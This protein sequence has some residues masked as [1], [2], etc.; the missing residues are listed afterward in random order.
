MKEFEFRSAL[1]REVK[2]Y[3]N[4]MPEL[5][6]DILDCS[7]GVNPYGYAENVV[8][9]I[10]NFDFDIFTDYPHSGVLR[11]QLVDYWRGFS[12]V[13][14]DE[15]TLCNGSVCGLYYICELFARGSRDRVIGYIPSFTDMI[16][17]VRNFGMGYD[18]V[19]IRLDEGG[20]QNPG[21]II[22]AMNERT[23]FIYIDRPNN[24]TGRTMPLD[25]VADIIDAAK[26]NGSYVLID[27][28]Y[29]DFI[30]CE[31]SAMIFGA[32]RDNLIVIKTFSKGFGLA[33]LRAGYIVAPTRLTAYMSKM[34]NPYI[35]SDFTRDICA[36]ALRY[37]IH[38]VQF[39]IR[40]GKAKEAVKKVM[41][42][43]LEMLETDPRV[44]ICT[45]HL[46]GGGD[47]QAELIK[48]GVLTV[49]GRE[50]DGLDQSYVRMRIPTY[51]EVP[52]LLKAI[53][54]VE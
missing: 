29:G 35:L 28:A 42:E 21:D 12:P 10:R 25:E 27:E 8:E 30:P 33:N 7:L 14:E 13:T 40:F 15:I 36:A 54:A 47:L 9:T 24:P 53:E 37:R 1:R 46:R 38:P 45:L 18:P 19:P 16:E 2:S 11:D 39:G 31:E 43:R 17:A 50:F 22:E 49:S 20:V 4:H 26:E 34:L 23:A 32:D 5:S 52:R 48:R 44:P 3:A 41:G 6:D 51:D